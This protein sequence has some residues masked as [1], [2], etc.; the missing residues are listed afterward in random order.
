MAQYTTPAQLSGLFK[1]AYGDSIENLVPEVARLVKIVKFVQRDKE[2]GNKYHQPVIVAS[3]Q[4]VTYAAAD[5]GAFDLD[6]SVAMTMQDA[7][8][9]G[10]QMLLRSAISYD[11]AARASNSKKAFVKGTELLVENMM[12]SATKR[13]E[14]SMLHGQAGIGYVANT[15]FANSG[16]TAAVTIDANTWATGIWS[17]IE[18]AKLVFYTDSSDTISAG[19]NLDGNSDSDKN[20]TVTS[21]NVDSRVVSVSGSTAAMTA[22]RAANQTKPLRIYFKTSV[23]GTGTTFAHQDMAGLKKQ[24]TNSGTLFNINASTYNLWKGNYSSNGGTALTIAKLLSAVSKAVQRGLNEKV[25]CFVNP[26]T[27]ANL[28]TDLAALRRFDGSYNSKKAENGAESICF[29]AQNGEIEIVSHNVVKRGECFVVPSDRLRRIGAR[30]LSFK[31]PG[32]EDEIFLHLQS[33]A[34]FELR[35]YSDQTLFL[36]TPARAVY[37]DGIINS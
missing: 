24:L 3:E 31:T 22:L 15:G 12:E 19:T 18:G 34:G 17:G 29:Y 28:M 36:E 5:S 25:H 6:D 14:I 20:I 35:L 30:D 26:D 7:Q 2:L 37:I 8:V 9:Q 10:S 1:E 21:V 4:G 32:R 16:A 33:K 27:W 11:S 13:L 23:S